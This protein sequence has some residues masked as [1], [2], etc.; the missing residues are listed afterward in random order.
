MLNLLLY[1]A[2]FERALM[3]AVNEH[4]SLA[5]KTKIKASER[6][7]KSVNAV[8][9]IDSSSIATAPTKSKAIDATQRVPSLALSPTARDA[10]S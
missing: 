8:S 10:G 9:A 4:S 6:N 1:I 2:N 5:Q 3:R 7:R